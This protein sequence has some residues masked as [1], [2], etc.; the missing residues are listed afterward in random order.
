M[1]KLGMI[2]L[3]AKYNEISRNQ[4]TLNILMNIF[5]ILLY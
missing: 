3:I 2:W 5:K 1:D 4:V